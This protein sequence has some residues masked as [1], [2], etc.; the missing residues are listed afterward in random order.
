MG[1]WKAALLQSCA[2][3]VVAK[4]RRLFLMLTLVQFS[5]QAHTHPNPQP[6]HPERSLN[7]PPTPSPTI[8]TTQVPILRK[9]AGLARLLPHLDMAAQDHAT[10]TGAVEEEGATAP[11]TE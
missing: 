7:P 4:A 5:I 6:T 10:A 3:P 2:T 9:A 11:A 8:N 1:E